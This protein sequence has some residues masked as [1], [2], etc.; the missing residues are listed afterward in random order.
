MNNMKKI[1]QTPEVNTLE[2]NIESFITASK[3]DPAIDGTIVNGGE[4]GSDVVI[5]FD[6]TSQ[7]SDDPAAKGTGRFWDDE[8]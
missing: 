1:Y 2:I 8:Y 3:G 6:G 5:P 7:G 4:N